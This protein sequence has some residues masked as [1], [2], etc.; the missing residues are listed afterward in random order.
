MDWRSIF[1]THNL[2]ADGSW[3]RRVKLAP[4]VAG[5]AEAEAA[6]PVKVKK[7]WAVATEWPAVREMLK[8]VLDRFPDAKR[9][10]LEGM[11][12]LEMEWDS[13]VILEKG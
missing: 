3:V 2:R 13:V 4:V 8:K 5:A 12:Q 10:V 9:A 1:V 7:G 6:R 11:D